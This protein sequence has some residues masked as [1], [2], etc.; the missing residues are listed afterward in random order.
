M[1]TWAAVLVVAYLLGAIPTGVLAG[2]LLKGVDVRALGSGS[3]GA[4]NV[5]RTFGV[6]V[7][8]AVFAVDLAKGAAAAAVGQAL[9]GTPA[10]VAA[11]LAAI[12]GHNWPVYLRFR[13]GRGVTPFFGGLA[14]IHFPVALVGGLMA[15]AIIAIFRYV[16]L[17]SIVGTLA[18]G[19]IMALLF[20]GGWVR[21][22][23][24]AYAAV[25]GLLILFQHR[26]N[27]LRLLSGRERKLSR[28]G[29]APPPEMG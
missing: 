23:L 24:L 8:V 9:L 26:G 15:F 13:G 6:R 22:E 25:G 3:S 20:A 5:L 29:K 18:T 1:L 17:G 11:A 21:P 27:I 4:T 12:V 19:A 28:P 2:K 10:A 16:S 7:G 14:V